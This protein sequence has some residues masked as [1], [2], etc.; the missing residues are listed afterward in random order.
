M[1]RKNEEMLHCFISLG[2]NIFLPFHL[3][4]FSM[5]GPLFLPKAAFCKDK[6]SGAGEITQC[7]SACCVLANPVCQLDIAGVLASLMSS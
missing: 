2:I 5:L 3:V 7:V 1:Q 4:R 6:S